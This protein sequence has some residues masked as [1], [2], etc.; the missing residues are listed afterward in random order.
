MTAAELTELLAIRRGCSAF[1]GS[2][3]TC[4]TSWAVARP[5][6]PRPSSISATASRAKLGSL[7]A[8]LGGLDTVVFTAGIGE[9]AAPVRARVAEL[10]HWLGLHIDPDANAA[11]R[12]V[13][14]TSA[15]TVHVLVIPTNEELM[16][17][18]HTRAVLAGRTAEWGG[19]GSRIT[20]PVSAHVRI[21]C[22]LTQAAISSRARI[23]LVPVPAVADEQ[24][25]RLGRTPRAGGVLRHGVRALFPTPPGWRRSSAPAPPCPRAGTASRR[26]SCSRT[27]AVRSR[28]SAGCRR[29]VGIVEVHGHGPELHDRPGHLGAEAERDAFVG[30]DVEHQLVGLAGCDGAS[31]RKSRCGACWN[32]TTISGAALPQPL[33]RA[34]V[35]RHALPAPVVDVAASAPRRSRCAT[36]AA[37]PAPGGSPAPA[38]RPSSPGPYWPRTTCGRARLRR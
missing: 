7:A 19:G 34:Q 35:D 32:W 13:L 17:A 23:T 5:L 28:C 12:T 4:A 20:A 22:R 8:A 14:H 30:L 36:R 24:L 27:A 3:P 21:A 9:H 1:P 25:V 29:R 18:R 6:P 38:C 11:S 2:V 31:C 26:R 16:I 10:A 37:R 33:A 15:S